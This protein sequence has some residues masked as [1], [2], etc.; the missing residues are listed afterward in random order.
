MK[1]TSAFQTIIAKM[2]KVS[3]PIDRFLSELLLVLLSL[4]GR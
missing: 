1:A 3:K 4:K 2:N